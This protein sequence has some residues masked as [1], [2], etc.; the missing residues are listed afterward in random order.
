MNHFKISLIKSF[1]RI[2]GFGI[3]FFDLAIGCIVLMF[4]EVLGVAEELF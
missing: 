4:A 2:V 3:L 1:F